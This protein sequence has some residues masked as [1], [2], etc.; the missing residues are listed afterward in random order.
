[1]RDTML[2]IL[3]F[4]LIVGFATYYLVRHPLRSG[5]YIIGGIGL[6]LLGGFMS[7]AIFLVLAVACPPGVTW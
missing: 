7:V 3:V 5:K 6:T 1:M 2:T 4:F